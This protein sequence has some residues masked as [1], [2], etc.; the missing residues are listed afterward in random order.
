MYPGFSFYNTTQHISSNHIYIRALT[1]ERRLYQTISP[2]FFFSLNKYL[3]FSVVFPLLFVIYYL[4][5]FITFLVSLEEQP[6]ENDIMKKTGKEIS[7]QQQQRLTDSL[8][9]CFHPPFFFLSFKL[10]KLQKRE[11]EWCARFGVF[12]LFFYSSKKKPNELLYPI[13]YLQQQQTWKVLFFCFWWSTD[14]SMGWWCACQVVHFQLT[15]VIDLCPLFFY[16]FLSFFSHRIWPNS[17][18]KQNKECVPLRL[19]LSSTNNQFPIVKK[20]VYIYTNDK[21][22]S[23]STFYWWIIPDWH[24]KKSDEAHDTLKSKFNVYYWRKQG[25]NKTQTA[26]N[27]K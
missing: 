24:V 26:K 4:T 17:S 13:F 12:C 14:N 8:C 3:H 6:K 15:L 2:F 27:K 9:P 16:F 7:Y 10:K 18:W 20:C 22:F 19:G 11:R 5:C 21:S 23:F 25:K 1:N